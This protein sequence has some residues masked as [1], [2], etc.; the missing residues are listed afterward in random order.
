MPTQLFMTNSCQKVQFLH[1]L[2][3]NQQ[4]DKNNTH[5]DQGH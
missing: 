2:I 5:K 1:Q 3:R 4:E